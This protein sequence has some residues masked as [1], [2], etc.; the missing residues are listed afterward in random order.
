MPPDGLDHVR[1]LGLWLQQYP[2]D[3]DTRHALQ[4][5]LNPD[6]DTRHALQDL[7]NPDRDT[8]HALQDLLNPDANGP[9]LRDWAWMNL[10]GDCS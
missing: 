6:R 2:D 10:R 3:R 5:L 9:E 8:R 7:L 4:D 1:D